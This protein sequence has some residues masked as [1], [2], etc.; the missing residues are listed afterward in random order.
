MKR[1]S[2]G[3]S[4]R[5]TSR[6]S[7]ETWLSSRKPIRCGVSVKNISPKK[8]KTMRKLRFKLLSSLS[9]RIRRWACRRQFYRPKIWPPR[10]NQRRAA[11][12]SRRMICK[13]CR[14]QCSDLVVFPQRYVSRPPNLVS[15]MTRWAMRPSQCSQSSTPRKLHHLCARA[16]SRSSLWKIAKKILSRYQWLSRRSRSHLSRRL[17]KFRRRLHQ[18]SKE[19]N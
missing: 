18:W 4:A 6:M 19:N 7:V 9:K 2:C 10:R 17:W 15:K 16:P 5:S 3:Y 13:T 12:C 8:V 14:S 1:P 11:S